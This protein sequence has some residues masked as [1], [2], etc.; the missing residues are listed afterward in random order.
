MSIKISF[1]SLGCD[2]NLVDSEVMLGLIDEE[3]YK[4]VSDD[5]IAD[6]IIVNTCCF[7]NDAKAESIE[8]ILELA[9]YKETGECKALI[10]TG[11]M[12][13]RYKEEVFN[14]LPEVDAIVG[15]G[16]YEKII[17]VIKETLEGNKVQRF[18]SIDITSEGRRK[19]L[20]STPGYFEYIKIAEG[21]NNFCTYCIIPQ[22]RGKYRSR[23]MEDIVDEARELV[24]QGVKEIIL[25]AQDTTRYG[26]DLYG[27][28]KLH[29]LLEEL[30]KIEDLKWI[31]LMYCYPEEINDNLIEAIKNLDKVCNYI[32]MPIQ[33]A[34]DLILKR[35]ARRSNQAQLREVIGKLRQE[36]PNI[37][38][39]T[40]LITG[41]PGETEDDFNDM[42]QF[43][44]DMRFNRLGAFT[45]SQEDGTKAAKFEDQVD[46]DIKERRKTAIMEAQKIISEELSKE[47]V[48]REL[49]TIIDGKLPEEDHIYCGRTY[50]DAP[51]IDGYI[52][53][54][55]ER[56]YMSGDF[57]RAKVVGSYEYDLIGEEIK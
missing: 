12:A 43:I 23:K 48:G 18:D 20:I 4:V 28:K 21:C 57:T 13:E 40:T 49:D 31:R 25:V 41:F 19:R 52:F 55:S 16:S 5:A 36:I 37:S 6:V 39:R 10:V 51:D 22:L 53:V 32:D 1:T 54:N 17:E 42:L 33:H 3:G 2:K 56:N 46:D 27:D 24:E 7:I 11:C 9:E 47:Q 14:E 15:T 45:Y 30:S 8:N 34:N 26:I 44:K 38:L 29:I 35:M 50:M